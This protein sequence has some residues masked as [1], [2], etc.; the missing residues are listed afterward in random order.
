[1]ATAS[2]GQT[3]VIDLQGFPCGFAFF[4]GKLESNQC[5]CR[6]WAQW[7]KLGPQ[8]EVRPS[9]GSECR[10]A[11]SLCADSFNPKL[12]NFGN[13]SH[14]D[15]LV[16]RPLHGFW[17][18]NPKLDAVDRLH[19]RFVESIFQNQKITPINHLSHCKKSKF[20][21]QKSQNK[22]SSDLFSGCYRCC[23]PRST[24]SMRKISLRLGVRGQ[25]NSD[26]ACDGTAMA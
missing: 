24:R 17:C 23:K 8:G 18:R 16:N 21:F 4:G 19:F 11:F 15:A 1:M 2:V 5:L 9:I 10:E 22:K 3:T 20:N 12:K 7:P 26:Y 25:P 14:Y 13:E 6:I